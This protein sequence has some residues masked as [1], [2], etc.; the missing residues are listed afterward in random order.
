MDMDGDK[1]S[2]WMQFAAGS[3]VL[4]VFVVGFIIVELAIGQ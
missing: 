2:P 3:F 4:I 1:L